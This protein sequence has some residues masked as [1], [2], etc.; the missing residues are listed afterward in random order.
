MKNAP[1]SPRQVLKSWVCPVAP[2]VRNHETFSVLE[3]P[4][5]VPAAALAPV[6]RVAVPVLPVPLRRAL[7]KE[8]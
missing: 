3:E 2:Q 4:P 7:V 5:Q 6:G 1:G 8:R